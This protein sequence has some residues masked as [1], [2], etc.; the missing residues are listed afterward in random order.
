MTPVVNPFGTRLLCEHIGQPRRRKGGVGKPPF[1]TPA[2]QERLV[3]EAATGVFGTA[4][5][6]RDWLEE[7]FG[8]VYAVGS[9]SLSG[10]SRALARPLFMELVPSD[11]QVPKIHQYSNTHSISRKQGAASGSLGQ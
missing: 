7:Q 3:A 6:V 11:L 2:Q 10:Y 4:A 1:L 8:V 5:A 9:L